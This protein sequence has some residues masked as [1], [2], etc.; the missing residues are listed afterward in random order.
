[1]VF[2]LRSCNRAFHGFCFVS[3]RSEKF[4]SFPHPSALEAFF[5]P[6]FLHKL[7]FAVFLM[8][9]FW[10]TCLLL[11][12]RHVDSCPSFKINLHSDCSKNIFQPNP[13]SSIVWSLSILCSGSHWPQKCLTVFKWIRSNEEIFL[14][15][16]MGI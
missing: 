14:A 3:S 1:M 2:P 8:E 13:V 5:F 15:E 9:F 11:L 12:L 7:R 10:P 16:Q 6:G 4:F